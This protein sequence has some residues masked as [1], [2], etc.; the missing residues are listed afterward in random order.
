M[1]SYLQQVIVSHSRQICDMCLTEMSLSYIV[2]S[3]LVVSYLTWHF[4]ISYQV[5]TVVLPYLTLHCL[6]CFIYF[7]VMLSYRQFLERILPCDLD[8]AWIVDLSYL[9]LSFF[10]VILTAVPGAYNPLRLGH[11]VDSGLILYRLTGILSC[12]F[13]YCL[14][15]SVLRF[16]V[17]HSLVVSP[18]S[19][20]SC[21]AWTWH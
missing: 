7:C 5:L 1:N 14:I 15:V 4:L 16:F 12:V 3:Y 9:I 20:Y 13:L 17:L 18:W 19:A 6:I 11:R 8:M 10:C 2:L 21:A